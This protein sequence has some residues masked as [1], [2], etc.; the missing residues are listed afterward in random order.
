MD[1]HCAIHVAK[2]LALTS[3]GLVVH[4]EA[5]AV[6]HYYLPYD[7][8]REFKEHLPCAEGLD[9]FP[10]FKLLAQKTVDAKP[11]S[12]QNLAAMKTNSF[13]EDK[14]VVAYLEGGKLP[15]YLLLSQKDAVKILAL[16][17]E[18]KDVVSQKP[19]SKPSLRPG[20]GT[21]TYT[22]EDYDKAM[23]P[24]LLLKAVHFRRFGFEALALLDKDKPADTF[25]L[26]PCFWEKISNFATIHAEYAAIVEEAIDQINDALEYLHGHPAFYPLLTHKPPGY[27]KPYLSVLVEKW[28]LFIS[29]PHI[30]KYPEYVQYFYDWAKDLAAA[31]E[32]LKAEMD[33][34]THACC[35]DDCHPWHVLLGK[36]KGG[37]SEYTPSVFRQELVQPASLNGNA[38]RLRKIKLLHW[39]LMMMIRTFDLPHLRLDETVLAKHFPPTAE[40]EDSTNQIERDKGKILDEVKMT[41]SKNNCEPLGQRA[42]PY[43]Y[44]IAADNIYSLHGYWDY[45]KARHCRTDEHLTYNAFATG[46]TKK[47]FVLRP[48]TYPIDCLPFLRVE[49]HIGKKIDEVKSKLEELKARYNLGFDLVTMPASSLATSC[50]KLLGAEHIAGLRQHETLVLVYTDAEET[51]EGTIACSK[52]DMAV[53]EKGEVVADF[54]LPYRCCAAGAAKFTGTVVGCHD[55]KP[56]VGAVVIIGNVT[57]VTDTAGI[58]EVKLGDGEHTIGITKPDFQDLIRKVKI[59]GV[60]LSENLGLAPSTGNILGEVKLLGNPVDKAKV[61]MKF[62]DGNEK[63]IQTKPDGKF[64][65]FGVPVNEEIILTATIRGITPAIKVIKVDPCS[66]NDYHKFDFDP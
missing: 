63:S 22:E 39:R 24:Q 52:E 38:E 46:Y 64:E 8:A 59:E 27:F 30:H 13:L 7:K 53:V 55:Q 21:Y 16:R 42:I 47:D 33:D 36:V 29:S 57:L 19:L 51:I 28:T 2:G 45:A 25:N 65:F 40:E 56:I 54:T 14:V 61:T 6:F 26:V 9:N 34:L 23:H 62:K 31:Y 1:K 49:G 60:D 58:F 5:D 12:P 41:P 20:T 15:T 48:L 11:L 44:P 37:N 3:G 17:D 18:L 4:Q 32:E 66:P 43:Y 10:V 50:K 35:G